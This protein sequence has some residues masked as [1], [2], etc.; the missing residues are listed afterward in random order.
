[1]PVSEPTVPPVPRGRSPIAFPANAALILGAGV[2]LGL[3]GPVDAWL[4]R[5]KLA[6]DETPPDGDLSIRGSKP[7]PAIQR[8]QRRKS[9]SPR[10]SIRRIN[11]RSPSSR[12][13]EVAIGI[14]RPPCLTRWYAHRG[15]R[16][17][18]GG[19][20]RAAGTSPLR[21]CSTDCAALTQRAA[22]ELNHALEVDIFEVLAQGWVRVPAVNTAVQLSALMQ[23]PPALVNLDRHNIA[24]TSD[25]VLD[26]SVA[27]SAL[28]PLKLTLEIVAD[29]QAR[30]WPRARGGSS[31]SRS[32]TLRSPRGLRTGTWW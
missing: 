26:C 12:R 11:D 30:P 7:A 4:L 20:A 3:F 31:W 2:L 24:S 14:E 29:I 23:G 10:V 13:D 19:V 21:D 15:Y 5:R 27:Q 1:V 8:W 18:V 22:E 28:P 25:V 32:A 17:D 9:D 6:A 16:D